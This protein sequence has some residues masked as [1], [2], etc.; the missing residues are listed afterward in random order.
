MGIFKSSLFQALIDIQEF[1]EVTLLNSHKS[2]EQKLEEVKHMAEQCEKSS[3]SPGFPNTHPQ[4]ACLQ[5]K[6][7]EKSHAEEPVADSN[8]SAENRPPAVQSSQQQNHTPA[9]M[10]PSPNPALMNS[11]WYHY[12]DDESPPEHSYPRLTG[13]ARAPEL[14]HVSER[15]LSEIENVHGFVSHSHISPMKLNEDGCLDLPGYVPGFKCVD[16]L[17]LALLGRQ[18]ILDSTYYLGTLKTYF[19]TEYHLSSDLRYSHYPA[20]FASC[21]PTLFLISTLPFIALF[22]WFWIYELL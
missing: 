10:N 18:Q 22:A 19:L 14:V 21:Y 2:C 7:I 12:Q 1:Y 5:L 9:C 13:E 17:G 6:V 15:N 20:C 3:A 16:H 4:P 11:P 8:T